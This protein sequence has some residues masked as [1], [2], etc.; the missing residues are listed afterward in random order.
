MAGRQT[1][2][3][4][5]PIPPD[6]KVIT[7]LLQRADELQVQ[8]PVVTYWCAYYAAKQG[9]ALKAS[10]NTN[11][12]FLS[13]LLTVLENLRVTIGPSDAIDTTSAS[14][15][16]VEDFALRV[17]NAADNED[18]NGMSTRNTAKKFLAA[19]TFLELL[20]V[21]ED[22]RIWESHSDKARYAKWKATD[23][24][25]AFREGRAPQP[26]PAGRESPSTQPVPP[27]SPHSTAPSSSIALNPSPNQAGLSENLAATSDSTQSD[28]YHPVGTHTVDSQTLGA[29]STSGDTDNN[30][31]NNISAPNHLPVASDP[32]L[33]NSSFPQTGVEGPNPTFVYPSS[34]LPVGLDGELHSHE[35]PFSDGSISSQSQH[36]HDRVPSPTHFIPRDSPPSTQVFLAT[37]NISPSTPTFSNLNRPSQPPLPPFS[38]PSDRSY[39]SA[40]PLPPSHPVSQPNPP[41]ELTSSLIAKTQKHCRFAISALD[42]EDAEQARKELRAAL[43]LLGERV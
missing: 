27:V 35:A 41:L 34:L 26:G 4:L 18:R 15:A 1:Y 10:G 38:P 33:Y 9:I 16:Y 14:S 39:A 25:K 11:R 32:V 22:K 30:L 6:L 2:L 8:D 23:I 7:S 24:A 43:A 19:A 42:Y 5:P 21:F 12:D 29:F 28:V 37:N 36:A 20:K 31:Q 17:F 40:P 13:A 3:G